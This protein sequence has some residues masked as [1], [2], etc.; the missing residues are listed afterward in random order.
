MHETIWTVGIVVIY[1]ISCQIP[2]LG[3]KTPDPNTL[4]CISGIVVPNR[5]TIMELSII[6]L[7]QVPAVV[8]LLSRALCIWSLKHS[9]VCIKFIHI[10]VIAL[11]ATLHV[12]SGTHGHPGDLSTETC[13][14]IIMQLAGGALAAHV[15]HYLL[16]HHGLGSGLELF[17]A[18]SFCGT[19]AWK[20][21]SPCAINIGQSMQYEGALVALVH[22]LVSYSDWKRGLSEVL[23]RTYLPSLMNAIG[24]ILIFVIVTYI[25]CLR[26]ELRIRHTHNSEDTRLYSIPFLYT[27]YVPVTLS[28]VLIYDIC[29]VS[30]L[31]TSLW[32][33]NIF[34][35][36]LGSWSSVGSTSY[37][38]SGLCYYLV[39]F[40]DASQVFMDPIRT[41]IYTISMM[42]LCCLLS[43]TWAEVSNMSP[44]DVAAQ[45]KRSHYVIVGHRVT[46]MVQVLSRHITTAALFGGMCVGALSVLSDILGFVG[47]GYGI[48]V[49]IAYVYRQLVR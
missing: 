38:T 8:Q 17:V 2:L 42:I 5:G 31:L 40:T 14:L 13:A 32:H 15:L 12:L 21:F 10:S 26:V 41:I 44:K 48:M 35:S 46:A 33:G 1:A 39:P 47:S 7:I 24:T 45:M 19:V 27:S 4:N 49:T 36:L 20:L 11:Y 9:A 25:Q 6:T 18:T 34:L 30:Q 3:I 22:T 16:D 29:L 23:F 37:I 28:M 43:S